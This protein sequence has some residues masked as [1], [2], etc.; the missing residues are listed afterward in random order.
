[1][2]LP[3]GQQPLIWTA[4]H[5]YWLR[6]KGIEIQTC[7]GKHVIAVRLLNGIAVLRLFTEAD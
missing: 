7:L 2:N 5:G 3:P 1:M 6:G 4:Q